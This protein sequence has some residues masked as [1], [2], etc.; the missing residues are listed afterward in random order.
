MPR[1]L[2]VGLGNPILGDDGV[3]W[4]VAEA[5]K[6]ELEIGELQTQSPILP[7]SI[8]VDCFALGGLS[9]MERLVGYDRAIVIDAVQTQKP[10]GTVACF[11]L[12]DFPDHAGANLTA[13]HDTSLP[14]ALALGRQLGAHLPREVW[15]V[16]IEA[17]QLYDFSET[18]TPAVEAA[19]PRAVQQT[20]ALVTSNEMQLA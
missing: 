5:V 16:G 18:L 11:R 2:I 3:G 14:K 15:V 6:R 10:P 17:E 4:K 8:D 9:L 7:S 12:E 20:L 1:T 13:A 19:V